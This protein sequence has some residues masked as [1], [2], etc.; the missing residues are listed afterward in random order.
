MYFLLALLPV[1]L[2][3]LA[4]ARLFRRTLGQTLPVALFFVVLV[5]YL[6]GLC[7]NL[8]VGRIAII[9]IGIASLLYL[10]V[11]LAR[12]I[13]FRQ[14]PLSLLST[15]LALVLIS[16]VLIV[17]LTIG[18]KVTDMDS[19]EQWGYIVKKMY[20]TGSLL[21]ARGQYASTL[22]YPPGMGLLQYYFASFS[23]SFNE[24][25]LF[26][27]RDL[28]ALSLLFPF[29][30]NL[31]WNRWKTLLLVVPIALLLPFL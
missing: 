5:V 24:A 6:G 28:L 25:D 17:L 16:A 22:S 1:L 26:R 7:G 4:A 3:A 8:A 10:F 12:D 18:R 19:F 23:P 9:L 13:G 20:F 2:L 27:A 31:D 14:T 29:F 11:S 30:H 21:S 15:D